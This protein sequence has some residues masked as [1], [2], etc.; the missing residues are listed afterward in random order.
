MAAI[1]EPGRQSLRLQIHSCQ[2]PPLMDSQGPWSGLVHSMIR[3]SNPGLLRTRIQHSTV[4]PVD[5]MSY[6][7][8][9]GALRQPGGVAPAS[10]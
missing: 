6:P 4:N 7:A 8:M 3:G 1:T 9:A 10:P 5:V 2:T